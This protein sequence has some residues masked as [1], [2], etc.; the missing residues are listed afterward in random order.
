MFVPPR[1]VAAT[2]HHEPRAHACRNWVRVG[3]KGMN[4]R[5]QTPT[6]DALRPSPDLE[7]L[8]RVARRALS[9]QGSGPKLPARAA[10]CHR[11]EDRHVQ[12]PSESQRQQRSPPAIRSVTP[13]FPTR[14][15]LR[16][17]SANPTHPAKP[18]PPSGKPR[19]PTAL[20]PS[21]A[22]S[23][24]GPSGCGTSPLPLDPEWGGSF[25]KTNAYAP[26][27]IWIWLR[28]LPS[29]FTPSDLRAGFVCDLA[30]RQFEIADTLVFGRP[31]S[32]RSWFEAVT[33]KPV[34]R[35]WRGFDRAL[36]GFIQ[37][38]ATAQAA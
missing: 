3:R 37:A 35:A 24:R 20:Q 11:N 14:T 21:P 29:P 30:F 31:Q 23:P 33:E 1:C 25:W 17:P 7:P 16:Q 13:F 2:G 6:P 22:Q 34:A 28:R 10:L 38:A 19:P 36:E 5:R 8:H 15:Q 18:S 32:G 12:G 26:Y 9:E 27:P 4:S